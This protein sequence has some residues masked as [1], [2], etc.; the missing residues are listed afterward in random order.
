MRTYTP[1]VGDVN[2]SHEGPIDSNL[3]I[4]AES[5]WNT[6]V[7]VGRPLCGASGNKLNYWLQMSGILRGSCRIENLYPYKPPRIELDSVKDD[8]L[9]PWMENLHQR[10]TRMPNLNIIVTMGNYATFALTGKGKVRASIRKEF[11]LDSTLAEKKAG[12]SLL[13]GSIYTYT[14]LNGLAI[15]VMPTIHPAAVLRRMLWE[16]RCLVDWKRIATERLFKEYVEFERKLII[17]P[18]EKQVI[19]YLE[20]VLDHPERDMAIDIECWGKSLSC[21]GFATSPLES[22]TIPTLSKDQMD[23]FLPYIK[24]LCESDCPKVL[25][26]GL[27]DWYWL[28]A[29]GI[30]L[31]NYRKDIQYA[32]H[33]LD[34]IEEH[35]LNFLASIYT[36]A[37]YWKD[38]AKDAEE[39]LKYASKRDALWNYNGLDCCHTIEIWPIIRWHLQKEGLLDFYYTHYADMLIHLHRTSRHGTR[40]NT[41]LQKQWAKKLKQEMAELRAKL[42]EAAGENLF[43]TKSKSYYRNPTKDEWKLLLK[44]DETTYDSNG[45]PKA[46]HIDRE[47]RK[48]LAEQGLT[49]GIT[50]ANAGKIRYSKEEDQKGFSKVKLE[51]F[52]YETLKLP[53][54]RK[55]GAN[56]KMTVSLDEG[57]IRKLCEKFPTQ[58]GDYGKWL[59]AYRE[60]EKEQQYFRGAYDKDGRLRC[61]Y[62]FLTKE[63]RLA[64]SKNPMRT[65][66]NMQNI[67]R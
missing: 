33:A 3:L 19:D 4:L 64:S 5:P 66:F 47:A 67:K 15:K 59:I 46:K 41:E 27:F 51:R 12:V 45:I 23:L 48:K 63:G 20:E 16:K 42:E 54:Q 52:F 61:S 31:V 53:K 9:I 32:H 18:S 24:K 26:N 29:Y 34:P 39:I 7:A 6:E 13:R 36:R 44:D 14:D 8:D 40:V 25:C 37:K 22:I 38:E 1:Y 58:I 30:Q 28:D 60:K 56:G 43:S 50:G 11:E 49:Y 62:K 65:G 55:R 57:A 10:I 17:N 21:V 2:P 35:S